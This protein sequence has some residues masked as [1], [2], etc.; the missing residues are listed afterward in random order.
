[1][2]KQT[3]ILLSLL[4]LSPATFA[5]QQKVKV[6]D[7][8]PVYAYVMIEKPLEFCRPLHSNRQLSKHDTALL[9]SIVGGTVGHLSSERHNKVQATI[10]GAVIGGVIG[11]QLDNGRYQVS[12]APSMQCTSPYV[13][14]EKVRVIKG[15]D[16]WYR[17]HGKLYKGFS[18]SEPNRYVSVH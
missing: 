1:M 10:I 2:K 9:G 11:S 15:Y 7:V 16:Y 8:A 13:K 12:N 6:L 5:K 14:A 18:K 17:I 3:I 4:A